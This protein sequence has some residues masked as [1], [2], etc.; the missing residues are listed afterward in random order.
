MTTTNNKI[1]VWPE[2]KESQEFP[3]VPVGYTLSAMALPLIS[4]ADGRWIARAVHDESGDEGILIFED[5]HVIIFLTADEVAMHVAYLLRE[6]W[7]LIP[8][9]DLTLSPLHAQ[10][11]ERMRSSWWIEETRKARAF[12]TSDQQEVQ[13]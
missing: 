5:D 7:N 11:V 3:L 10:A 4:A 12:V 2:D 13:I 1:L 8:A 6:A 9:I